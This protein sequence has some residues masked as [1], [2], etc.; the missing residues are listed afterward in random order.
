MGEERVVP[1]ERVVAVTGAAGGLGQAL[2]RTFLDAGFRVAAFG[3]AKEC[4]VAIVAPEMAARF[5]WYCLDVGVWAEVK[6]T[7]SQALT[8]IGKIDVL[9]NN[10]AL[11]PRDRFLES[12]MMEWS[13][14]VT[15]NLLGPAYCSRA[16]LP[17]MIERGHGRIFN[18]GSFADA[19]PIAQSS[20]YSVSKGGLHAL[21]KAIVA[22]IQHL[23]RDIQVHEWVPG[24][25]KTRMSDYTG[26]DPMVSAGWALGIVQR[27]AASSNSVLYVNDQEYVA[28]KRLK[29]RL[30]G[31]IG[32]R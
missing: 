19:A 18:V 4:P 32:L 29:D 24:H 16:V 17:S 20:A 28:P 2:V 21:S 26:L 31:K 15:V 13:R 6:N 11:Y 8:D 22:D 7:F 1:G 12:D 23:G 9:F 10:A 3:R 25:L 30:L 27:D 14:A 5:H